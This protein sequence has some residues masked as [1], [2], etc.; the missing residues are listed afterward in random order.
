MPT[1]VF[2]PFTVGIVQRKK[3]N[4]TEVRTGI[5]AAFGDTITTTSSGQVDFGGA[6]IGFGAPI[7]DADGDAWPTPAT[8][9]AP[10][11]HKNSL[12]CKIDV[13]STTYLQGGV[14]RSFSAPSSGEL[15]LDV[16]DDSPDDNSRGWT[17]FVSHTTGGDPPPIVRSWFFNTIAGAGGIFG[18]KVGWSPA[19]VI[20]GND[21]HVF[22]GGGN[23]KLNHIVLRHNFIHPYYT[24]ITEE[25]LDDGGP[26]GRT[27]TAF[28]ISA[29]VLNG[30]I[31]VLYGMSD[32]SS[33]VLRH[34]SSAGGTKWTFEDVDG[35][36]GTN[37]RI[38]GISGAF[39]T[40]IAYKNK[41][42]VFYLG[43]WTQDLR[44]ATFDST[45]WQCETLDGQGGSAGQVN[46]MVGVTM[47]AA[48]DASDIL[49]V[50][51]Y[52]QDNTNL[53]HAWLDAQ[54]WSFET[55]D[56]SG[57]PNPDDPSEGQTRAH[58]GVYPT[59]AVFDNAL[60]VFYHDL[61]WGNIRCAI[62]KNGIWSFRKLD[63]GG[64]PNGRVKSVVGNRLMATAV[65]S[66]QLSL[67]Y[68]DASKGNLRHAW[69]KKGS[70]WVF[71]TLDGEGG[72]QGRINENVGSGISAEVQHYVG[73]TGTYDVAHLFYGDRSNE[74]LRYASL[75]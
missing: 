52:D 47:C 45:S 56:G 11:L 1:K 64:G 13:V 63:G 39:N 3:G 72:N 5:Q 22:Y 32:S 17:V 51:Y 54:T 41:L 48:V 14:N 55:L 28:Q 16:N 66:D 9:P 67:F 68:Y 23:N 49:H 61:S 58:V 53:R 36:G 57:D 38:R 19:A 6:F 37:G 65:L 74:D 50:F 70:N 15:V 69:Q 7:L 73:A 26:G 34:A 10:S 24:K 18:A 60:H 12:I 20:L 44:H 8:Y 29:A 21:V 4:K 31:H 33:L 42:H 25:S 59:T 71:E 62:F 40:A 30:T 46:A 27:N 2:G 35:Q 75:F 43:A